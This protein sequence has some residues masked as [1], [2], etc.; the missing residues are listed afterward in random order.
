M[1]TTLF[2]GDYHPNCSDNN[3]RRLVADFEAIRVVRFSTLDDYAKN[4][5]AE[6][7]GVPVPFPPSPGETILN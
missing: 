5:C 1:S 6:E 2:R 7:T 3:Q 4:N